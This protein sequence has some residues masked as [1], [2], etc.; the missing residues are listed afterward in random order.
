LKRKDAENYFGSRRR[1]ADALRIS[2]SAVN[3]W[4]ENVPDLRSME[5]DDLTDGDLKHISRFKRFDRK[6]AKKYREKVVID[7]K[8][9]S[10]GMK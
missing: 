4:G 9:K 1:L 2:L 8:W 6:L 7:N 3:L 5:L 10:D